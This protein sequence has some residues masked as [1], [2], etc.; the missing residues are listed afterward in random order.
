MSDTETLVIV[1]AGLAGAKAAQALRERG[2]VGRLVLFGQEAH[3]PYERPPLSK[4]YL[5]G[6]AMREDMTVHPEEWY[7]DQR[8]ELRLG[9]PVTSVDSTARLVR[10]GSAEA[11]RY[12]RLLLATGAS[13]RRLPTRGGDSD[14]VHYLRTIEDSDALREVLTTGSRLVVIGAGW[15]GLE[16]AA[17]ARQAGAEVTVIESSALPLLGVLGPEVATVFAQLHRD[18]GVNFHFDATVAEILTMTTDVGRTV[19]AGVRLDGPS[20]G[21]EVIPADGVLVAIGA[22]PNVALATAAG[23][24]V[25]NGVLTDAGLR[26][27]EPDIFAVGDI[28][29][30][31]HPFYGHRIRVEHWANALNQPQVAAASMLGEADTAY[32]RLPYFFTDQYDL[33]MEYVGHLRPDRAGGAGYDRVVFRGDVTAREFIAFWLQDQRVVAAMAVNTWDMVEPITTLIRSRAVVDPMRLGDV[34]VELPAQTT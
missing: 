27:S 10:S 22:T 5:A 30:A 7:A 25:D 13:P 31:Q 2:F 20:D 32:D 3:L 6:S 33:G 15:I 8:I 12:D 23:L 19:A 17:A 26:T 16:V 21:G 34:T 18:H 29:N 9:E 24:A 11:V 1:G 28:A 14:G 4:G